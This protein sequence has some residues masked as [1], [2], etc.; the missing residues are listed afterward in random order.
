MIDL[1][2]PSNRHFRCDILVNSYDEPHTHSM[3][4]GA[5]ESS[6]RELLNLI[7]KDLTEVTPKPDIHSTLV[8]LEC[9][10]LTK[11][12]YEDALTGAFMQGMYDERRMSSQR[13][14]RG[15]K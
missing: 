6:A 12:E 4:T 11:K 14:A 3:V 8:H 13:F 7:A 2:P 15:G 5:A 10:V 9:Y 1:R